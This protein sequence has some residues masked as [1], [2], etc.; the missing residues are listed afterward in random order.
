MLEQFQ[1]ALLASFSASTLEQM[2]RF[3]LNEHL[4][5]IVSNVDLATASFNLVQWAESN[6]KIA[7]L[8]DAAL[9]A[10]PGNPKLAEFAR[11]WGTHLRSADPR[12]TSMRHDPADSSLFLV[13]FSRNPHFVG[14]SEE[15]KRIHSLLQGGQAVEVFPA[16]LSGMGGIGKTQMAV[17]YAF[18][19]RGDY[20]DGVYWVNAAASWQDEMVDLA[21]RMGLRA[22]ESVELERRQSLTRQFG[23]FLNSRTRSLVIF[24]NVEDPRLLHASSLGFVPSQLKCR[25]LFTTRRRDRTPPFASVEIRSLPEQPAHDL[26]LSGRAD[27]D[28]TLTHSVVDVSAAKAICQSLGYLPL[29]ISLASA[30]LGKYRRISLTDYLN[31]LKREGGLAVVDSAR[32]DSLDLATRH[33]A[34]VGATLKLQWDAIPDESA[35]NVLRAAALS[36]EAIQVSRA[37][38]ALLTGLVDSAEPGCHTPLEEALSFLKD[39]WLIEELT[40]DE[41]RLHPLI[42]E[43][44]EKTV[45]D[46][47]GFGLSCALALCV[48]LGDVE[49]LDDEIGRRGIYPVLSDLRSSVSLLE[50]AGR[51]AAPVRALAVLRVLGLESHSLRAWDRGR[52]PSFFLQQ[53]R[54]RSLELELVD[55]QRDAE[56]LLT[57]RRYSYLRER[58]RTSLESRTLLRTLEGHSAKVN[59]VAVTW[60]GRRVISA[61]DDCR[62]KLW[63]VSSGE[64]LLSL[65]GHSDVV[66]SV[67]MTRDG[68]FAVSGSSD[69]TARVWDLR[70]GE[71][72][73]VLRR[74]SG[75]VTAV[76]LT[77]IGHFAATGSVEGKVVCGIR[78]L[79]S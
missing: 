39:L 5:H 71:C 13:P 61:S 10:N 3:K 31:R 46:L 6:G 26:L 21:E 12:L 70:N 68:N 55:L 65:E 36:R 73:R 62:I 42:R 72:L 41:V 24:D 74:T 35:R 69:A 27:Y 11:L 37:R 48:A 52:A 56:S 29:A 51:F 17:E 79:A 53:L 20:P 58:T 32:I 1:E 78:G 22:Y 63:D 19:H 67:A 64:V 7:A 30:Y 38:L 40:D 57:R 15:M 49:R 66:G 23:A 45:E 76:A 4:G 8:L 9:S 43:F 50:Q 34:A 59:A 18:C 60:D 47:T 28:T 77:S 25:L 2:V 75:R 14:R 16:M 33:M 44:A 54:N